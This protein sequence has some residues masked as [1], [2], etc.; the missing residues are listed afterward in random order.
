M[1]DI[2]ST[3]TDPF[4]HGKDRP[5]SVFVSPEDQTAGRTDEGSF[6]QFE[7]L[8]GS[9][10]AT[11]AGHRGV[12]GRYQHHL[13]ARPHATFDQGPLDATDRSVCGLPG[14]R[15]LGQELR[16]EVFDRDQVMVS[17]DP[18]SPLQRVVAGLPDGL[19]GDL[20]GLSLR[21]L[22]ALRLG[23]P[24][25]PAPAGHL[26][27]G[28]RQFGGAPLPVPTVGQVIGRVGGRG[29][30]LDAPVDADP[31]ISG[32]RQFDVTAD[33]ERHVPVAEA[34]LVDP[35]RRGFAWK[36]P[37][38]HDG[39]RHSAGQ[40]QPLVLQTEPAG[41]VLQRWECLA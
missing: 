3:C 31:T 25:R 38:P 24:A 1:S 17:D 37:G 6:G 36:I 10:V 39:D 13:P 5:R 20:R 19:L 22:V 23:V 8:R 33:H 35:A 41:R 30:G 26:P 2:V 14:H 40:A 21:L 32:R 27:L 7:S 9:C 34:V 12:G 4:C 29:G 18:V 11:R 15:G 16:L 28:L